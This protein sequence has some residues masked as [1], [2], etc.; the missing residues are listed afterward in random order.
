MFDIGSVS[1]VSAITYVTVRSKDG[2]SSTRPPMLSRYKNS[3]ELKLQN[4]QS[5]A[6]KLLSFR[7][8]S[9]FDNF[10]GDYTLDSSV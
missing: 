6:P 7:G 1:E 5:K 9:P 8:L 10:W 4:E 2:V 3:A